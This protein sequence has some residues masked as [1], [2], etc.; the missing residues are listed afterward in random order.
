MIRLPRFPVPFAQL[1]PWQIN[2]LAHTRSVSLCWAH[3]LAEPME[4]EPYMVCYECGHVYP[5]GL[6]LMEA[7]LREAGGCGR[8]NAP[9]EV[10]FC[11]ECL[12]DF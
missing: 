4:G 12:H 11:P 10:A 7:Y 8:Y 5:S 1:E 9:H 3:G 2:V 6:S